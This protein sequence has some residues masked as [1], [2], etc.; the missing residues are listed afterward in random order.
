MSDKKI[1]DLN[2]KELFED[3]NY[4]INYAQ[5]QSPNFVDNTFEIVRLYVEEVGKRL[6]R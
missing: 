4:Y 1:T 3:L 5:I 6:S 2:N